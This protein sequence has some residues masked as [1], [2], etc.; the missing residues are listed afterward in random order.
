M[1]QPDLLDWI[2]THAHR[3]DPSTS[4]AAALQ[5]RKYEAGHCRIIQLMLRVHRAGL[6]SLEIAHR[7]DLAYHEVARR[8]ADLKHAGLVIDS[9]TRRRNPNGRQAAVWRAREAG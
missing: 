4:V 9:G 2:D 5:V 6:T 3:G 8:I 7:T 1:T